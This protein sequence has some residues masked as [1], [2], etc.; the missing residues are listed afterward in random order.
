MHYFF[1]LLTNPLFL[2]G[3]AVI[4]AVVRVKRDDLP[5]LFHALM[6]RGRDDDSRQTPP[7]LPKP[8]DDDEPT[9]PSLPKP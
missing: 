1:S 2:F 3:L 5:A 7:S 8:D 6:G 9:P 4:V